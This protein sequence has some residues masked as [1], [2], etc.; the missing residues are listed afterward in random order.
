MIQKTYNSQPHKDLKN[1][2]PRDLLNFGL[3]DVAYV[4]PIIV[5]NRPAFA[6]HAAD[7]TPLSVMESMDSA[8]AVIRHNDLE[9]ATIN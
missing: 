4:R 9:P 7:G 8:M 3:Q 2:T 6:I 1:L 5:E